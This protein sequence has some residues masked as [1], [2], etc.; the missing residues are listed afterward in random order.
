MKKV[1]V[2]ALLLILPTIALAD[3]HF[4]EDLSTVAPGAAKEQQILTEQAKE[5]SVVDLQLTRPGEGA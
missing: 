5:E 3:A 4:P 2:T 1:I